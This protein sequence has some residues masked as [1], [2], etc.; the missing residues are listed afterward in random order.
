MAPTLDASVGASDS[1]PDRNLL[2]PCLLHPF[3]DRWYFFS[4]YD[5]Q[6]TSPTTPRV[7]GIADEKSW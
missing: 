6:V 3:L 1:A 4:I 5:K 2:G 7:L